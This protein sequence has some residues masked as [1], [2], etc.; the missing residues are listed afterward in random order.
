MDNDA[1][2]TNVHMIP[3]FLIK[4]VVTQDGSGLREMVMSFSL[5][6]RSMSKVYTGQGIL[7]EKIADIGELSELQIEKHEPYSRDYLICP[8]CEDKLSKLEAFF[9]SEFN[10]KKMHLAVAVK[11]SKYYDNTLLT[12]NKYNPAFFELLVQSIFFRCSIG[13]YSGFRLSNDVEVKIAENLRTAFSIPD[14]RKLSPLDNFSLLYKFPVIVSSFHIPEGVDTTRSLITISH[15]RFPYFLAA[16]K[17]QFQMYEHEK[18]IKS[19]IQWQYGLS[20]T[21]KVPEIYPHLKESSTVIILSQADGEKI[22]NNIIHYYVDKRLISLKS[23]IQKLHN[24]IFN[25]KPES[26]IVDYILN[27][28]FIHLREGQTEHDALA[29]ALFDLKKL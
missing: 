7:P 11:K 12:A 25:F 27:Q 18:H 10:D 20:I 26:G 4:K 5:S 24:Q 3:W 28:Y 29:L 13:R 1:T 6:P 14:F 17:W 19:A 23:D 2:K 8:K 15:S 21:L 9:A 22:S 16:G